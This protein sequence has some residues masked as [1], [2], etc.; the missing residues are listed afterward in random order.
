MLLSVKY[1][2]LTKE[3]SSFLQK[4]VTDECFAK[5]KVYVF[6]AWLHS[7]TSLGSSKL[8]IFFLLGDLSLQ[9]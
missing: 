1:R 9:D 5:Y 2:M 7:Y 6:V 3:Y 4:L 8:K